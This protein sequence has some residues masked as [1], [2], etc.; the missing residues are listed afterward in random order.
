M[1]S[2]APAKK[3]KDLAPK[4]GNVKGGNRGSMNDNM[5]LIRNAKP[6]PKKKD[7][8]SKKTVTGGKKSAQDYAGNDNLTLVR[9]AK[10]SKKKD[11]P[12]RKPV[13]GGRASAYKVP[14]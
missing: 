6:T 14:E 3:A 10:P 13:K 2:K 1:A 11:L 5:T 4:S 9:N 12:A 8:P 7:L